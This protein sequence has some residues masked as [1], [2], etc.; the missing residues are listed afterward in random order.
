MMM[1][2]WTREYCW[3]KNGTQNR[4]RQ[5]MELMTSISMDIPSIIATP[6]YWEVMGSLN[7]SQRLE[8]TVL[9]KTLV[10]Y[11]KRQW[12]KGPRK[13]QIGSR[14]LVSDI[15]FENITI[16]L[17]LMVLDVVQVSDVTL[18]QLEART[19]NKKQFRNASQA[20]MLKVEEDIKAG[21]QDVR[22]FSTKVVDSN[23][24]MLVSVASHTSGFWEPSTEISV[25]S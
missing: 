18:E 21:N 25:D 22:Y 17:F 8:M 15:Y 5:D 7:T 13:W 20:Y 11:V 9:L 19:A 4:L 10:S 12:K 23:G 3:L 2:M 6:R 1:R 24:K 16:Y 14:M